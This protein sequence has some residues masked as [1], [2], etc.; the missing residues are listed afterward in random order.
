LED[1][2]IMATEKD[3]AQ[4]ASR[5]VARLTQYPD[6]LARF[7]KILAV[8]E[9]E[10]GQANT[11]DEAEELAFEQVRRLGQELLQSWAERKDQHLT[12]EYDARPAYRRK[13]KK[14]SAG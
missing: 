14:N 10:N 3:P 8:A 1:E 12:R 11:A 9:N 7:E 5:L 4:R 13:G 2:V 6:L